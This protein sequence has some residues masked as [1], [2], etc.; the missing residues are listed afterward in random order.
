MLGKPAARHQHRLILA[1]EMVTEKIDCD[2]RKEELLNRPPCEPRKAARDQGLDAIIRQQ[3]DQRKLVQARQCL[4]CISG[5]ELIRFLH[6]LKAQVV[7]SANHRQHQ[8]GVSHQFALL[9]KR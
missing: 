9:F 3:L 8:L 4:D 1:A 6:L 2:L 7:E 5:G